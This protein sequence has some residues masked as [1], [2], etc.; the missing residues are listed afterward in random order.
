M[1]EQEELQFPLIFNQ[2]PNCGSAR[3]I[4][5]EVLRKR[6]DEGKIAEDVTAWLGSSQ[7]IIVDPRKTWLSAPA[8]QAKFDVCADCGTY[9]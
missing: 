1:E 7:A 4:A 9:Y 8:I 5:N 3:R 6:M 2:C